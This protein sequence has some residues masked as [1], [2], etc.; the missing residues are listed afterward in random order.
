[1]PQN[2][3]NPDDV[4]PDSHWYPKADPSDLPPYEQIISPEQAVKEALCLLGKDAKT[5]E[6]CQHLKG[7]GMELDCAIIDRVRHEMGQC[8]T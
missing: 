8:E 2:Q 5:E 4:R 6:V 3:T 1:M 7:R